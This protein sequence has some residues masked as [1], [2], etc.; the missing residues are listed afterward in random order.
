VNTL[1]QITEELDFHRN[2]EI[3][4]TPAELLDESAGTLEV[5]LQF[6]LNLFSLS[7]GQ[8]CWVLFV[9][10]HRAIIVLLRTKRPEI[11]VIQ[12]WYIQ[13][14]ASTEPTMKYNESPPAVI[15]NAD[16]ENRV[17]EKAALCM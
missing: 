12:G 6:G 15:R 3:G 14:L 5:L 7:V 2:Q 8:L 1:L 4:F 17:G 9:C 10:S 11:A 16:R 13:R